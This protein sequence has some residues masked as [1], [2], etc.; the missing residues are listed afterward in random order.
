MGIDPYLV[1]SSVRAFIAQRLVRVLCQECKVPHSYSADYLNSIGF[2][3]NGF[4]QA[5]AHSGCEKCRYTGYEG[6]TA[7]L[8]IC[9]M[10][11]AVQELVQ[12]G[13]TAAE[14]RAMALH[15]GMHTLRQAG[16]EKVQEG[17]TTIEEVLRVTMEDS[18]EEERE[19]KKLFASTP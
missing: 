7:I 10:T 2:P 15:E 17:K 1:C 6:R 5:M 4:D 14:I 19:K 8:E 13:K 16:F 9:R 3:V 12:Q 11:D 18:E